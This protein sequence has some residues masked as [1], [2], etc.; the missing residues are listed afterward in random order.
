LNNQELKKLK[1]YKDQAGM[2]KIYEMKKRIEDEIL[3]EAYR[4]R[5]IAKG[6]DGDQ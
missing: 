2:K 6:T 5:S 4:L 3:P 1:G